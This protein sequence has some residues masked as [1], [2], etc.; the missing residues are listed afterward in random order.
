M[1]ESLA[2]TT[3]IYEFLFRSTAD[4]ILIASPQQVL[5]AVNPA[6]AALLGITPDEVIGKEVQVCFSHQHNLLGLFEGRKEQIADIRLPRQRLAVGI[7]DTLQSGERVVLLQDVTEK[8]DIEVR[9]TMLSKAIVH[10]LRNPMAAMLGYLDLIAKFGD[11][12]EQQQRF[13]QRARQ[14]SGKV[15]EL[16]PVLV[17]LAWIEAGMPLAHVPIRLSEVID[18]AIRDVESIALKNSIRIFT[19]I[20][21][22]LPVVM[23]DPE[24]L[25]LTVYHLLLNA[26]LY[27]LTNSSVAIH[28]WGDEHQVYCSVAD[29]GIG[30]EEH[31]LELIFDRMY[32]AEDER[33]RAIP[34]GGLGLTLARTILQRHGGDVWA[35]ST[36]NVGSTFTFILP[37]V[38]L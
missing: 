35:S 30:I 18:R 22:P 14:T 1:E 29:Q 27:S 9:R 19:S 7:A 37:S 13:L 10:D 16:V 36:L 21:N 4:G 17:D 3:A 31:D 23:G 32:R 11:L 8:R 28:S 25:L 26:T 38:K 12:N 33:V 20:Q 2:S 34:G 24:R 5:H 15:H 6:A